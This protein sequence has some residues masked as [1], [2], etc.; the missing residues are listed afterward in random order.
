VHVIKAYRCYS[1]RNIV[2]E[3][4]IMRVGCC[5]F[6]NSSRVEGATPTKF[7]MFKLKIRMLF[8]KGLTNEEK[9]KITGSD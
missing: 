4:E 2:T 9:D 3:I 6:C 7:E 8:M 1:C 5:P